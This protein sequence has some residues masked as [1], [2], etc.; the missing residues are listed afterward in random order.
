[1]AIKLLSPLVANQIAAGEV[2]ER[3]ASV[4]KELVENSLDAGADRIEIEV[5]E[6]GRDFIRIRDNGSGIAKDELPLA[7]MRHA[8][9][10]IASVDDLNEILS[11]G[12]RGEALAS[13]ASVARLRITSKPANQSEAWQITVAGASSQEE[14]TPASHPNG[15]T[16]EIADLFFNTPARRRFLKSSKTEMTHIFDLFRKL[17]LGNP[18]VSFVL[19][20]N[21]RVLYSLAA[22]TTPEQQE[23]R[24]IQLLGRDFA[25]SKIVV[26]STRDNCSLVGFVA[27]PPSKE[28]SDQE[29]QY[30]YLNGRSIRDRN[31]IHAIKQAY[32][33][34][35]GD[36]VKISYVL[37]LTMDPSDVDV[38]VHPTKHEVRFAEARFIHDFVML[39]IKSAFEQQG[40]TPELNR[41]SSHE[42]ETE[43]FVSTQGSDFISNS[44]SL[45]NDENKSFSASQSSYSSTGNGV[46]YSSS[47]PNLG[48]SSYHSSSSY[49]GSGFSNQ[50][51]ALNLKP[52]TSPFSQG[53]SFM[54]DD[55]P[56]GGEFKAYSDWMKAST[57]AFKNENE[58]QL[59]SSN[60]QI[61]LTDNEP[62]LYE[63]SD[64]KA[65]VGFKQ[66]LYAVNLR[67]LDKSRLV[68]TLPNSQEKSSLMLPHEVKMDKDIIKK[69]FE[70][71]PDFSDLGFVLVQKSAGVVNIISVPTLLRSYD[72]SSLVSD[73][74]LYETSSETS[75]KSVYEV[76]ATCASKHRTYTFTDAVNLICYGNF[77]EELN[78]EGIALEISAAD[79]LKGVSFE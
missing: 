51:R 19:K 41:S 57:Q 24:Y 75:V 72:L 21:G 34:I 31:I 44:N 28:S 26:Q 18:E 48:S 20:S 23:K 10:K 14:I 59:I 42:Y 67:A 3:P 70:I 55:A 9:S 25:T 27:P 79:I 64:F 60:S 38:N 22:A 40:Y 77:S 52:N 7:L 65:L 78:K 61:S 50:G 49:G 33:E 5:E 36:D 62:I 1:M 17:A 39:S 69:A 66:K 32:V 13:I 46:S 16:I 15:T 2:V 54:R 30:F 63:V 11:F 43:E 53:A 58:A 6:G 68:S 29:I 37:S 12:F 71:H 56:K 47:N 45:R 4:V 35:Y 8:T 74:L 73:L 76:L